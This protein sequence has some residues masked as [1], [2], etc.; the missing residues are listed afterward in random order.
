MSVIPPEMSQ[1]FPAACLTPVCSHNAGQVPT[2]PRTP[3]LFPHCSLLLTPLGFPP[4]HTLG[5]RTR[6]ILRI[7]AVPNTAGPIT[8]APA[9]PITLA[10]PR[11]RVT[12]CYKGTYSPLALY[13]VLGGQPS[14]SFQ[15][16]GIHRLERTQANRSK[17]LP[18]RAISRRAACREFGGLPGGAGP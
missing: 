11:V 5:A 12:A 9:G 4:G 13:Q 2:V 17:H 10:R 3:T 1:F 7:L 14:H 15:A 8:L 6:P 16:G 18:H